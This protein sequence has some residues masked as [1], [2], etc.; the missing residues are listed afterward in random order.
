MLDGVYYVLDINPNADFSP[1]TSSIS[2]A[3]A[4]GLSYGAIASCL[5]NLAAH[6]HPVYSIPNSKKKKEAHES[7]RAFRALPPTL[8]ELCRKIL[9]EI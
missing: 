6:R 7:K 9:I 8:F 4:A 3:E 5:V 2:A 1:D